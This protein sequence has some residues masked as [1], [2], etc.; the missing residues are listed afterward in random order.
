MSGRPYFPVGLQECVGAHGSQPADMGIDGEGRNEKPRLVTAN[1]YFSIYGQA[2]FNLFRF[3]Q[4]NC[5]YPLFT[6]VTDYLEAESLATDR[7]LASARGNGF[8]V[9]F[10]IF[11]YYD[12]WSDGG[13]LRCYGCSSAALNNFAALN[14][15]P[16]LAW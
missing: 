14:A 8:R 3:S 2:G 15:F 10:G 5:S 6:G 11:G 7:L 1:E 4:R 12:A 16:A 9:M 13:Y